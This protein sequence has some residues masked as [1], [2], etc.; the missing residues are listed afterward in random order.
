[1]VPPTLS[2][3]YTVGLS[4]RTN[5]KFTVHEKSLFQKAKCY[6]FLNSNISLYF[7]EDQNFNT[8]CF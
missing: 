4:V 1:M 7:F 5:L 8:K 2:G 3:S 6:L